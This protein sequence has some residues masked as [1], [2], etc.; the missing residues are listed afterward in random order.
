MKDLFRKLYKKWLGF[1]DFLHEVTLAITFLFFTPVVVF[2]LYYLF[3]EFDPLRIICG[4]VVFRVLVKSN[5][6]L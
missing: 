2:T 5:I 1:G 4:A 6:E 3:V